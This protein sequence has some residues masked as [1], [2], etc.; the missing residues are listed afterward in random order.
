MRAPSARLALLLL[1]P[2]SACDPQ[3]VDAVESGGTG[4]A[5]VGGAASAGTGGTGGTDVAGTGGTSTGGT[6]GVACDDTDDPDGDGTPN[7]L[8]MCPN[9]ALK[10]V[11]GTCGCEIPDEDNAEMASCI[12][13][14][15]ALAHRYSFNGVG[16]TVVDSG[17]GKWDA[18]L[19]GG[20][21]TS[22]GSVALG[23]GDTQ[24]YVNLR[25]GI[26]SKLTSASLEVWLTWAGPSGGKWQR[27]FDFGDDDTMVENSQGAGRTYL[28]MTPMLPEGIMETPVA[29]VAFQG[30]TPQNPQR[31]VLLPATRA[32]IPGSTEHIVF[33]FD[34]A[35]KRLALY[36]DGELDAERTLDATTDPPM[37]LSVINDINNWLGRSQYEA[38]ADFGGSID[39]FRIYSSALTALQVRTSNRAGP[40]PSFLP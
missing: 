24:E 13:L 7:C 37:S 40:N 18:N 39:E 22:E 11:P 20:A 9:Q 27:V 6:G 10:I 3:V 28:F 36:L 30:P 26:L 5:G 35:A 25:N 19:V 17:R 32:L 16:D 12:P 34:D 15:G 23:G 4:A 33:T 14:N 29:R 8:D 38:D 21:A 31:E 2:L 1:A